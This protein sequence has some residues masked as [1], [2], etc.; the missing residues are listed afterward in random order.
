MNS[1]TPQSAPLSLLDQG[2]R[3]EYDHQRRE[4][5]RCG[6]GHHGQAH[7]NAGRQVAASESQQTRSKCR[8]HHQWVGEGRGS[9]LGVEWRE[10]KEDRTQYGRAPIEKL[11]RNLVHNYYAHQAGDYIGQSSRRLGVP[12]NLEEERQ[13]V[14]PDGRLVHDQSL[15]QK[16]VLA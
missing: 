14:R 6:L 15:P 13:R 10:G 12:E 16:D 7:G 3:S 1:C 11:Q 2:K 4:D 8:G 9:E 5:D